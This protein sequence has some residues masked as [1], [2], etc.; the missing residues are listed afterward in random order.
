MA[1]DASTEQTTV[2]ERG[3]ATIPAT[4]R[5]RLDIEAGDKLHWTVT[6]EGDL[7]V[8]VVQQRYGAFSDDT[9]QADL[10]G[11]SVETHDRAGGEHI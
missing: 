6:D 11:D 2:S 7:R 4:I 3:M 1:T 5:R 10:G 9:L 8:A